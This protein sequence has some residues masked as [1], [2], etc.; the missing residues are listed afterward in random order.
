MKPRFKHAIHFHNL[1]VEEQ[2]HKFG[3]R[4]RARVL[5]SPDVKSDYH[6]SY[7]IAGILHKAKFSQ[8]YDPLYCGKFSWVLRLWKANFQISFIDIHQVQSKLVIVYTRAAR[9]RDLCEVVQHCGYMVVLVSSMRTSIASGSELAHVRLDTDSSMLN[10][11]SGLLEFS[12]FF[13]SFPWDDPVN[14]KIPNST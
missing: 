2:A 8:N 4:E 13:L 7:R 1:E 10:Q 11:E 5:R 12:F 6:C 14:E 9:N 3:V